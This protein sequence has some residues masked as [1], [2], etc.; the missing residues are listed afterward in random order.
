M[1]CPNCNTQLNTGDQFCGNC[2]HKINL[3]TIDIIP[4][5]ITSIETTNNIYE[6]NAPKESA[7][8]K[9]IKYFK[10]FRLILAIILGVILVFGYFSGDSTYIKSVKE[11]KF[12][13]STFGN[14]TLEEIA[15]AMAR[16]VTNDQ[17]I[18]KK[19][20]KWD[21]KKE[22]KNKIV[23][24]TCDGPNGKVTIR[25]ATKESNNYISTNTDWIQITYNGRTQTLTNL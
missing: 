21:M 17:S 25:I 18:N 23:T 6:N 20:F 10:R 11:I 12:E 16:Y 5:N 4:E 15:V 19:D 14:K 2:G 24:A 22:G 9:F 13:S 1:N 7:L 8:Q 3:T